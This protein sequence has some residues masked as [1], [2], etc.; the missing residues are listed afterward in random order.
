MAITFDGENRLIRLD[1]S[2]TGI[3]ASEVYSRW[4]DWVADSDNAKFVQAFATVGGD[5]LGDD[6][7]ITPYFF[8]MNGWKVRPYPQDY[9]LVVTQNFLTEDNVSPFSFPPGGFAIEVVRQFAL[10]TET[11]D[12]SGDPFATTLESGMTREQALR[13]MLAVLAGSAT[14][15]NSNNQTVFKSVDGLKERVVA[16][17]GVDGSRTITSVDAS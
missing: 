1:S 10:K 5:P 8:M 2:T 6:V 16:S 7:Y 17:V 14:G 13:I 9:Q 12:G 15:L 4:K 11:V 3:S